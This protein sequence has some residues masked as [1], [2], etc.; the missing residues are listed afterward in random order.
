M[1]VA[2]TTGTAAAAGAQEEEEE[3]DYEDVFEHDSTIVQT[4]T[5]PTPQ[6]EKEEEEDSRTLLHSIAGKDT[7]LLA[8]PSKGSPPKIGLMAVG[9]RVEAKCEGWVL[10]FFIV[11]YGS[12]LFF[13]V[14]YCSFVFANCPF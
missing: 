7:T 2:A 10:L 14:L 1:E 3:E 4:P 8:A 12:L 13:I 11:L 9:T 5:K 6:Q